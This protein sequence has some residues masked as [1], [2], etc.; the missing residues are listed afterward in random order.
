MTGVS[1][2]CVPSESSTSGRGSSA[3][4]SSSNTAGGV[5]P[6]IELG[7]QDSLL[8]RSEHV[9]APALDL[10]QEERVSAQSR[11][12]GHEPL[13]R[14]VRKGQDLGSQERGRARELHGEQ[15]D[16][17]SRPLRRGDTRVLVGA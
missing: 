14:L 12:G 8:G 1:R 10:A 13:D 9:G 16:P 6:S 5:E 15:L 3:L 7:R 2:T 11:L 17:L 4:L